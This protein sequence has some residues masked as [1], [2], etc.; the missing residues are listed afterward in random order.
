MLN[1]DKILIKPVKPLTES[2][3][4]YY[5]STYSKKLKDL[6]T[7]YI[8]KLKYARTIDDIN[9]IMKSYFWIA[10]CYLMQ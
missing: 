8:K 4:K 5:T 9:S 1:G 10:A 7:F 3:S 6:S 2:Y